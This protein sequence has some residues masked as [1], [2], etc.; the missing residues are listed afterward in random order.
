MSPHY[1]SA[2]SQVP[3]LALL[4]LPTGAKGLKARKGCPFRKAKPKSS[5]GLLEGPA[6]SESPAR[7]MEFLILLQAQFRSCCSSFKRQANI[8][9]LLQLYIV[10]E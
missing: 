7:G 3:F 5:A 9:L 6:P 8:I 1:T 4:R 2:K 10:D